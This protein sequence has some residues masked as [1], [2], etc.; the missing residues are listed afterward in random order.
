MKSNRWKSGSP[1]TL[2]AEYSPRSPPGVEHFHFITSKTAKYNNIKSGLSFRD[3]NPSYC[4]YSTYVDTEC[5]FWSAANVFPVLGRIWFLFHP[6]WCLFGELRY[7]VFMMWTKN[8]YR[9]HYCSFNWLGLNQSHMYDC[10]SRSA[11]VETK[12]KNYNY[13]DYL[14]SL[15]LYLFYRNY[16]GWRG[17]LYIETGSRC[18]ENHSLALDNGDWMCM[19]YSRCG[20]W[21][22]HSFIWV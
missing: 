15:P 19:W 7:D 6:F 2:T 10:F 1:K 5:Y 17:G 13:R 12:Y 4:I 16:Y 3:H 11:I 8:T 9:L 21:C 20:L 14:V 18:Q 22:I